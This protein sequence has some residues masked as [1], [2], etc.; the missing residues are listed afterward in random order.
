MPAEDLAKYIENNPILPLEHP[1]ELKLAKQIL[2]L[3]DTVLIVLDSLMLHQVCDYVYN[4]ATVFHDFYTECYVIERKKDGNA[5][6]VYNS[7]IM[8]F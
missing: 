5:C 4:L 6:L 2:K 1:A 8:F 7:I 3:S